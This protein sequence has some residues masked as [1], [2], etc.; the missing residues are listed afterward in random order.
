MP[1]GPDDA[2]D[3]A[4]LLERL[5]EDKR[6]LVWEPMAPLPSLVGLRQQPARAEDSLAYLH[7]HW[8]LPDAPERPPGRGP[9]ALALR[10]LARLSATLFRRYFEAERDLLANIVRTSEMLAQR[11]DDLAAVLIEFQAAHAA[12]DA[13]LAAWLE[14]VGKPAGDDPPR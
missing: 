4:E 13:Q 14:V 10:L 3:P 5:H 9:R 7:R 6:R 8:A 12:H 11:C 2:I 1:A